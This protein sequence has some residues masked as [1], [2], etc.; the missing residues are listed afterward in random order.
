MPEQKFGVA[1]KGMIIKDNK[2]LI[3]VAMKGAN[4]G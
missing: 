2:L 1:T 3:V 4:Y